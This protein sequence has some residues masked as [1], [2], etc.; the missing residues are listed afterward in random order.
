MGHH[1][2][3]QER[4]LDLNESE[5]NGNSWGQTKTQA[6]CSP[7]PVLMLRVPCQRRCHLHLDPHALD[8]DRGEAKG[9]LAGAGKA[10]AW[11]LPHAY[12]LLGER[13]N[14]LSAWCPTSAFREWKT[15]L[16][17]NVHLPHTTQISVVANTYLEYT[18]KGILGT[19]VPAHLSWH[20][21]KPYMLSTPS[22]GPK[23]SLHTEG[24]Q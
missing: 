20:K 24:A 8:P 11:M 3:S 13:G 6:W 9:D 23:V 22:T 14:C 18:G 16:L 2:D 19:I 17:F 5:D 10:A 1:T 4:K 15:W 12:E 21:T 7:L